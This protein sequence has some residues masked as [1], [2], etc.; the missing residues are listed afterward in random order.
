MVGGVFEA[1]ANA[2]P[3]IHAVKA[4]RFAVAGD[5]AHIMPE[6]WWVIGYA[7]VLLAAAVIVFA[8]R[9]KKN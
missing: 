4:A 3:F 8:H 7:V 5:F 1:I 9:L 2:L 6:L